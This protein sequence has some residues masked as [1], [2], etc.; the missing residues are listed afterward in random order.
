[1]LTVHQIFK[2]NQV[3]SSQ[4]NFRLMA[5]YNISVPRLTKLHS[6][7]TNN[8]VIECQMQKLK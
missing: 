5:E 6:R 7:F 1:M 4:V 2:V 8:E 3:K